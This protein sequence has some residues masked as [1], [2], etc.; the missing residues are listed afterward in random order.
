[1]ART[2]LLRIAPQRPALCV[3]PANPSNHPRSVVRPH[4]HVIHT[5]ICSVSKGHD[6]TPN[7]TNLGPALHLLEPAAAALAI[8]LV[9]RRP[10]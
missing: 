10:A 2:N 4:G 8:I 5:E 3:V 9:A 7:S 6:M 1:M